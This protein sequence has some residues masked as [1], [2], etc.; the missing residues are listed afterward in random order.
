M[1]KDPCSYDRTSW[2]EQQEKVSLNRMTVD[3]P[4]QASLI[5]TERTGWLEL[6]RKD[7]IAHK[8]MDNRDRSLNSCVTVVFI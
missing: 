3:K 8:R 5:K 6:G 1:D 7:R 2:R 4:G